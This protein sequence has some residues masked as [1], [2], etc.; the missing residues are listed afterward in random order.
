MR[1]IK[2]PKCG[3]EGFGPYVKTTRNRSGGNTYHKYYY[4]AHKVG[5]KVKWCYIKKAVA[6]KLYR[7]L[8]NQQTKNEAENLDFPEKKMRH[9]RCIKCGNL[10][11]SQHPPFCEALKSFLLWNL[12]ELRYCELYRRCPRR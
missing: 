6:E 7:E 5:S 11:Q 2:C 10:D 8:P 1:K 9:V 4:F 12:E 3:A